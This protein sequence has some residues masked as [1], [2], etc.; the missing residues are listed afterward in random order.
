MRRQK[1]RHFIGFFLFMR[2][3][4]LPAAFT[5]SPGVVEEAA[6]K[7]TAQTQVLA[8]R[9]AQQPAAAAAAF[10]P[11]ARSLAVAVQLQR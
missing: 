6:S 3:R 4:L 11:R 7:P 1:M 5:E 2:C 10:G 8:M 9:R